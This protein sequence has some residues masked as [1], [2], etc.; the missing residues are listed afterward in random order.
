[1]AR[2]GWVSSSSPPP[3]SLNRGDNSSSS[4]L[5][6]YF[7]ARD[8]SDEE[9][10]AVD[11][12]IML[13]TEEEKE[14]FVRMQNEL[15]ERHLSE[16][17]N[18]YGKRTLP[19][20]EEG[21]DEYSEDEVLD[22][23][24]DNGFRPTGSS[25]DMRIENP[26]TISSVYLGDHHRRVNSTTNNSQS[27]LMYQRTRRSRDREA[28]HQKME[29]EDEFTFHPQINPSNVSSRYMNYSK[30]RV[31]P[32][33]SS[34]SSSLLGVAA[35]TTT[36]AAAVSGNAT[37]DSNF[38]PVVNRLRRSSLS[39]RLNQY[40]NTPVHLRLNRTPIVSPR[41]LKKEQ[42]ERE[43]EQKVLQ[44]HDKNL[45][46]H[47][48]G[49][50]S[51]KNG[52]E[53]KPLDSFLRRL[54]ESNRRREKNLEHLTMMYESE[55]TF[56]P[57]LAPGTRRKKVSS[58][59]QRT[60]SACSVEERKGKKNNLGKETATTSSNDKEERYTPHINV[61][62]QSMRRSVDDLRIFEQR[63][64]QRLQKLRKEQELEASRAAREAFSNVMT[65]S[66]GSQ[67]LAKCLFGEDITHD[68]IQQY[69]ERQA[70]SRAAALRME[71]EA[72]QREEEMQFTFRPEVHSAPP[73][74]QEIARELA[75]N[76]S[77][78]PKT[79][80]PRPVFRFS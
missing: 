17:Y 40:L 36:A 7:L 19:Y 42:Q 30:R 46:S 59:R 58:A 65:L 56:H 74:V 6:N 26:N 34:S 69:L 67:R 51:R 24:D 31:R 37:E 33:I 53:N 57:E 48:A 43:K 32:S 20:V 60:S 68:A 63:R 14:A 10:G 70:H 22:Y 62:S 35:T 5:Q 1:M 15:E 52:K 54:E 23:Y 78:A 55:L 28:Q 25:V 4:A 2:R 50:L 44:Q 3:P 71:Y 13:M 29:L 45:Q 66:A 73:Y 39:D 61:R 41:K 64:Q 38:K 11:Q 47:G 16:F 21:E 12:E 49:D 18:Y 76:K 75:V 77:L 8:I 72:K 9:C 79:P 27:L 80:K